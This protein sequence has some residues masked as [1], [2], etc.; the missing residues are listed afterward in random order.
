MTINYDSFQEPHYANFDYGP[1][2]KAVFFFLVTRGFSFFLLFVSLIEFFFI[3]TT[4]SFDALTIH[5]ESIINV[6]VFVTDYQLYL[7]PFV[8]STFGFYFVL[9]SIHKQKPS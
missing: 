3:F 6:L 9:L 2:T 5:Y 1:R 8:I 7:C 4:G